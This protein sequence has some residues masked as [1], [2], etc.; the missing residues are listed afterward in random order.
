MGMI[1]SIVDNAFR[2]TVVPMV[3]SVVYCDLAFGLADHSRIYVG[4]GRIIH[5]N[6]DGLIESVSAKKFLDRLG[7]Y[8]LAISIYVS[9]KGEK[10]AGGKYIADRAREMRRKKRNYN[11]VFDN[12]HQFA[13]GCVT[14]DFGNGNNFLWMLK[15]DVKNYMGVDKWRVWERSSK[16]WR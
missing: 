8:N 16:S 7:G 1:K 13:S 12:C 2:D 3:G 9:C 6:G 5:L 10:P 14:G 4:R 11:F 15:I